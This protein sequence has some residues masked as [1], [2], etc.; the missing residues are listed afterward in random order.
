MR[1][2]IDLQGAQSS[3]SRHRGIGRYSLALTEGLLRLRG[4]HQVIVALNGRFPDAAHELRARLARQMDP[5]DIRVWSSLSG[6]A[7]LH[8]HASAWVRGG[9]ERLR[10]AFL[11]SLRPDAVVVTSLFEGLVD[12]ATTSI[13]HLTTP[14]VTA[15]VLYDL[16]PLINRKPYLENPQVES[17]YE[18][19]V[20]HLRRADLLLSISE[21]SRVEALQHLGIPPEVCTNISTAADPRFRPLAIPPE[22]ELSLRR[23]LGLIRPFVM[24]TGGIDHRKNIEG[25]IRAYALLDPALRGQHQLAVV[26]AVHAADRGRLVALARS[27]GLNDD[28]LVLTGFVSDDDLLRLYNLCQLFVFPSWHEGFGLP[29][30]EAMACGRPVIAANTSSLPEVV[31]LDD[32]LFD[33]FSDADIAAKLR[34]TL[35][36]PALARRLAQAGLERSRLFSWDTTASRALAALEAAVGAAKRPA[37]APVTA[38]LRG[39]VRP[40]LAVVTPLVPERTG[41]AEYNAELLPELARH[42]DLTVVSTQGETSDPWARAHGPLR[43]PEWLLHNARRFDHVLHHMGNSH[44]HRHMFDLVK[45]CPGTVL[46][47]DFHLGQLIEHMHGTGAWPG[48]P[49][50]SMHRNHGYVAV[51]RAAA[52][53]GSD[54]AWYYPCNQDILQ[55]ALGIIVHSEFSRG[56][57]AQWYGQAVADGFAVV[58]HLRRPLPLPSRAE[59]RARLGIDPSTFVVC[60]FGLVGEA[61]LTLRLMAAF[62]E[63]ADATLGSS[64]LRLVGSNDGGEYG[65]RVGR[66]IDDPGSRGRVVLTGW[67]DET[68]YR[69]HLAAADVAV[70]LRSRSRGE[71]SG[72]L[73]DCMGAGLA[74]V[75]NRNGSLGEI[76]GDDAVSL[77]DE[78]DDVALVA[79]LGRLRSEPAFRAALGARA[80]QRVLNQHSPAQCAA[81]VAEAIVRFGTQMPRR[82]FLRE[83]PR[84]A[85]A[86]EGR[87][88]VGAWIELARAMAFSDKPS[89]RTPHLFVDVSVLAQVDA[90]TGI[91]RVVRAVL[92]RWLAQPPSGFRVEPVVAAPDGRFRLARR[93]T[94]RWLGAA[95]PAQPDPLIES[96]AGDHL[97]LLDYTPTLSAAH[98]EHLRE[99]RLQ[100]VEVRFVVYDLLPI[101]MPQH[102][103]A[104]VPQAHQTWLEA[105][106]EADGVVCISRA[107]ADEYL[108]W[109]RFHGPVRP[110]PLAVSWFHLGADFDSRAT[111]GRLP[112]D[113][114]AILLSLR[115]GPA[116]MMVGTVEPRKRQDM[117]LAAME[118]LW[119]QGRPECLVLVGKEG[120]DRA[121]FAAHLRHHPELGRRLFWFE[122]CSDE[123]LASLYDACRGLVA[124]S[125]GEGFG[126]AVI[127]AQQRGLDVLARDLP[128]FREVAGVAATFFRADDASGLTPPLQDWLDRLA[129]PTHVRPQASSAKTWDSSAQDLLTEVFRREPYRTWRHDGVFRFRGDDARLPLRTGR[130]KD[131]SRYSTGDAGHLMYGPFVRLEQGTWRVTLT[132]KAQGAVASDLTM[133]ATTS[134]GAQI[135]WQCGP[136]GDA[137]DGLLLR[138]SFQLAAPVDDFELRVQVSGAAQVRIDGL[139]IEPADRPGDHT[140][141][142]DSSATA[143]QT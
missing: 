53:G 1:I 16:I 122:Q 77:P 71:T 88:A 96:A 78:F 38:P 26:C 103:P 64:Q 2:V 63:F 52:L 91:Q 17:W 19:K 76:A 61:K 133:E 51:R 67:A 37:A 95:E 135:L 46:L 94:M 125:E 59:A 13:G 126:L 20:Q 79:A 34:A 111:G 6:A 45:R 28:E 127:E 10:E 49:V 110:D 112:V 8:E 129:A 65:A 119:A 117:V 80:R 48:D 138:H 106:A 24:Y 32:A 136:S 134:G 25:L 92:S 31:G 33:P 5:D 14:A 142:Q 107:V 81:S 11:A 23:R 105:T 82:G 36:D 62:R 124:A 30:L 100:G 101:Q 87:P 22:I 114:E 121:G 9:S 44:F 70:Q 109:L 93:F 54:A 60:S 115:R 72:A 140:A 7:E 39:R 85:A 130:L 3:G 97:V 84:W 90:R 123:W 21:S 86:A 50:L 12:D 83:L 35:G 75:V 15:A 18:R 73:L 131:G 99:L 139:V 143:L 57:A 120:W 55:H 128:V 118:Q 137:G 108:E 68:S 98:R 40:Q 104:G 42:F 102:F 56:L 58:P 4:S 113:A 74:T 89:P 43:S 141:P 41:I 116:I 69:L 29:A 27:V 66:A 132:G 47:H